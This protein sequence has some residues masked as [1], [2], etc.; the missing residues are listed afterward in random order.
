MVAYRWGKVNTHFSAKVC[1]LRICTHLQPICALFFAC[2]NTPKDYLW[3]ATWLFI[4]KLST[5]YL[6][7]T[8]LKLGWSNKT[9]TVWC[10][11]LFVTTKIL[12]NF[13]IQTRKIFHQSLARLCRRYHLSNDKALQFSLQKLCSLVQICIFFADT[14]LFFWCFALLGGKQNVSYALAI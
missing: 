10:K 8:T 5:K 1:T 6:C 3:S 14:W 2:K 11:D 13:S 7:C 4:S 12:C 9:C